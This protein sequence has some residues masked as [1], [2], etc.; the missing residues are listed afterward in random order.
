MTTRLALFVD[1]GYDTDWS[2]PTIGME[3]QWFGPLRDA[4]LT[5]RTLRRIA[6]ISNAHFKDFLAQERQP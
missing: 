4:G 1:A 2:H 3:A 6:T 5:D